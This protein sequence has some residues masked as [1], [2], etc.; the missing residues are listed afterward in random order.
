MPSAWLFTK[1]ALVIFSLVVSYKFQNSIFYFCKK[2]FIRILIGIAL[3]LQIPSDS[4][5]LSDSLRPMDCST[6]G[7]L[8][9]TN[10]QNL[11][12]LMPIKLV[13]P[14]NHVIFCHPLFLLPSIFPN[15]RVFFNESFLHIGWS[16]YWSFSVSIS[17]SNEY[18]GLISF[19]MDWLISLLSKR[20]SKV[21]SNTTVLK[22]QF[23]STQFSLW[24]N[25]HIRA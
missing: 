7:F 14:S 11:L 23:F 15:I 3:N 24:S 25:Y 12:R 1:S 17:F 9:I 22:Y 18:S 20:L 8:F 4:S 21:F 6:P 16:K 13:M 19:R 2:K 10:S 5:V